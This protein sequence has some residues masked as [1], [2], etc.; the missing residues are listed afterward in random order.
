M[1]VP[2]AMR[3]PVRTVLE[4]PRIRDAELVRYSVDPAYDVVTYLTPPPNTTWEIESAQIESYHDANVGQRDFWLY[5]RD[6]NG[7]AIRHKCTNGIAAF[8]LTHV[9][10]PDLAFTEPFNDGA[11][12]MNT[13]PCYVHRLEAPCSIGVLWTRFQ[14][15]GDIVHFHLLVRESTIL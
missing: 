6:R 4:S 13:G 8:A 9:A 11:T 10:G 3:E 2:V 7:Q 5:I 14:G 12:K 1:R 15:A